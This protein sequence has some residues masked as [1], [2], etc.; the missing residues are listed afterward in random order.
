MSDERYGV[1]IF[2]GTEEEINRQWHEQRD[3]GIG[4]S[5][6]AAILGL[7]PWCDV[8]DLYKEKIGEVQPKDLSHVPAVMLGNAMEPVLRSEY[9]YRH[10]DVTVVE[11]QCMLYDIQRP[12]MQASLDGT[13]EYADGHREVLEIKTAGTNKWNEWDDGR[14]PVLYI[15]QVLHYMAVTGWPCARLIAMVGN[16]IIERTVERDDN[17]IGRIGTACA[18]FWRHVGIREQ[19]REPWR[20]VDAGDLL[21]LAHECFPSIRRV[22]LE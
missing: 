11:P 14:V 18:D 20:V 19:P 21:P 8:A 5:N 2:D 4:G 13:L 1:I 22:G 12:Y 7:N 16:Q 6:V 15:C 17:I 9:A 3:K 10:H